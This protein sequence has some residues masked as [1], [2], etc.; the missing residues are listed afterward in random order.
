MRFQHDF[1]S[2]KNINIPPIRPLGFGL[3]TDVEFVT[4]VT[5]HARVKCFWAQIRFLGTRP[6]PPYGRHGL[7]GSWGKDTVRQVHF[8]MFSMYH[9]APSA[10]SLIPQPKHHITHAGPLLTSFGPKPSRHGQGDLRQNFSSCQG[11]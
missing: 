3:H 2:L 10:L 5:S 6:K 4:G 8:G 7:A 1:L 11:S 9:F